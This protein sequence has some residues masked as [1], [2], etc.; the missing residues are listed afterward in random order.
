[1]L[2]QLGYSFNAIKERLKQKNID[3]TPRSLQRLEKKFCEHGTCKD[4]PRRKR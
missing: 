2:R 1:M 4:L 3:I